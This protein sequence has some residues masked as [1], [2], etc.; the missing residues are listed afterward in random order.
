VSADEQDAKRL[1]LAFLQA[2]WDGEPERGYALCHPD[3]RWHFQRSLHDPDVVPVQQAVDW[4]NAAL[5][6]GFDPDSGYTVQLRDAIG[7]GNEAAIEYSATGRTRRGDTYH[8]RYVVRFTVEE[9]RI[10]SIRPYFDTH[11][12]SRTLYDLDAPRP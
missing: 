4:L 9:G 7:E 2:F 10:V 5:V 8:N 3:A 1:G 12:V 11:Y 6:S